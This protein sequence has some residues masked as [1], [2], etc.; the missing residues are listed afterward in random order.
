M[1][2]FN[3][4]FGNTEKESTEEV[5]NIELP[6]HT[7]VTLDLAKDGILNLNKGEFLN[8]SKTG[9]SLSN[10]RAAAGWDM[11][12]RGGVDLDLC[13]YLY[14]NDKLYKTIYYGD[15]RTKGIYLDG[16]N[17]TGEGDGDDE[18]I[19]INF[20]DLPSNINK[21]TIAVVIYSSGPTF[22]DVQN[23]YVRLV[24]EEN[25]KE[26]VRYN[27]TADGGRNTAVVAAELKKLNNEWGFYA[28]GH[29]S[30]NSIHTLGRSL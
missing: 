21:I 30:K 22:Q 23:A 20:Y 10:I 13:A 9:I 6:L 14:E 2:L 28:I 12:K 26:L 19:H 7:E 3:K 29:Y 18:N 24:N 5:E 4:L 27:L 17:L 25:R 16:D 15:K 1:G 8:L 11:S